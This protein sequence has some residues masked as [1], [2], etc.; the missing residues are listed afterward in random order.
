MRDKM[1][2]KVEAVVRIAQIILLQANIFCIQ[3]QI[4]ASLRIPIY[5]AR[6]SEN[7]LP[8]GET[9]LNSAAHR[10]QVAGLAQATIAGFCDEVAE[11]V[12]NPVR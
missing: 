12:L 4:R 2:Y 3:S 11:T 7:K 5:S 6:Q 1:V 8:H 9:M 10:T